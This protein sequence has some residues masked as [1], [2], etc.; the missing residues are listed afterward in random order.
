MANISIAIAAT[1][2]QASN[3]FRRAY[4]TF[5]YLPLLLVLDQFE[6]AEYY[7][8][9]HLIK[10]AL[11]EALEGEKIPTRYG[12][13]AFNATVEDF[14]KRG[15]GD[16]LQSYMKNVPNYA[17]ECRKFIEANHPTYTY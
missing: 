16:Q 10:T 7:L 13:D 5:G 6:Q 8:T 14:N 11:L 1:K 2:R 17:V 12:T 3:P 15:W 9:C 4:L